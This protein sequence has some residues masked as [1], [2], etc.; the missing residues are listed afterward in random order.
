MKWDV[1]YA[2]IYPAVLTSLG[3]SLIILIKA[4]IDF[5]RTG[6]A[7]KE[8]I[9]KSYH[10]YSIYALMRLFVWCVLINVFLAVT[11]T[12]F[13]YS[14]AVISSEPARMSGLFISAFGAIVWLVFVQFI[15]NLL[16]I[17]CNI[18][19]SS[20]YSMKNFYSLWKWLSPLKLKI[21]IYGYR[22]IYI[23]VVLAALFFLFK[24]QSF[25]LFYTL[26]SVFLIHLMVFILVS[27]SSSFRF[28]NKRVKTRTNIIHGDKPNIIMIGSDTLRVDR[29]G[30][31]RNG[32]S[33]TPNIDKLIKK[34]CYFE[35]CYVPIART[36]PSLVSLFSGVQPW[37][38][39]IRDN[40]VAQDEFNLT[41]TPFP[42]LLRKK[43][44]ITSVI[45]DWCGSD[46][47]KFKLGFEQQ[48]LP[49]DQWNIRYYIRQGP[50]DIRLFLSLFVKNRLGRIFLPEIF[51]LGGVPQG[52]YLLDKTRQSIDN[53]AAKEQP[54]LLNTFFSTTHPPF[55]TEYPYYSMYADPDYWGESKFMMA[56]LTDPEEII[57]SQKEPKEAF[58]L[59]QILDL[60]DGSVTN[61]D[62]QVG[63]IICCL[64]KN[65]M[66]QNTLI[67]IYSDH[68][69]EFFENETWGQGNSV[70]SE[71]S[72]RIPLIIY[73]PAVDTAQLNTSRI[74]TVDLVPTLLDI[75]FSEKTGAYDGQS[76]KTLIND[77]LT[78][79][80]DVI[81]ETGIWF[82][83]PPGMLKNHRTYPDLLDI[84]TVN[85]RKRGTI[86]LKPELK[87]QIYQAKDS[88]L[89]SGQWKLIRL[90]LIDGYQYQL[91]DQTTDPDCKIDVSRQNADIVE[92][93]K[94]K[95]N[96]LYLY[97]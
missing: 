44:Y 61:F 71:Y 86:V 35:N 17:P 85:D 72:N 89:I 76:L 92:T 30:R 59:E 73:N 28:F 68:G 74:R 91:Y 43:G 50:K 75:L 90:P 16:Y 31:I 29:I 69:M 5:S 13:Y 48:D 41:V 45:S 27:D 34:S 51:Y 47:G 3:L 70:L 96:E 82:T 93:L 53:L 57:K 20:H 54:F 95:L 80:Q 21:I 6:P 67:V 33:I 8:N 4:I 46:L 38:H 10:L 87:E 22:L 23:M 40:F 18:A 94:Q 7:I 42:E 62:D 97:A 2:L 78:V 26:L 77:K 65:K 63:D 64:K 84:I 66:E 1:L 15:K 37:K 79:N 58:D 39:G 19:L 60:Y 25:S 56:R 88:V 9:L 49:E 32:Q 11:G 12:L 81:C 24:Q 52:Q 83:K 14:I 36:A 55:G